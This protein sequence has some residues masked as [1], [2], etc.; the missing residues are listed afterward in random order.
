M[1]GHCGQLLQTFFRS[2]KSDVRVWRRGWNATAPVHDIGATSPRALGHRFSVRFRRQRQALAAP[3]NGP[4]YKA[5]AAV[6][7][8]SA[9]AL[10]EDS[11]G[12]SPRALGQCFL[13]GSEGNV[14]HWLHLE[15]GPFRPSLV[16]GLSAA[17]LIKNTLGTNCF[18]VR[19]RRQRQALAAP[20]NGPHYFAAVGGLSAAALVEDSLGTSP[21]ALGQC[22]LFGSEG[23]VRHWL[24]LETGPFRPSLV[25][26]LSAAALV[27]DSLGTNCF[28]VRFRR[29]RQALAAPRNGPHYKAFAAVGGLVE[30][31]LEASPRALGHC[32]FVRFRRQR[33]A[34]AAPRNG[35]HY[36]AFAAVGGLSAAALVEDSLGTSPGRLEGNL[37]KRLRRCL[38]T[39][40]V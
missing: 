13:F 20:R 26:G 19:F 17:A 27:E 38:P 2:S 33:Q 25:G 10:V 8:L 35:P 16:G 39:D 12:T 5:F 32:F 14:R 36:K 18:S 37:Q 9:A 34:L 28:F 11:L 29:Q 40:T 30:D 31:S 22:F 3:R 7:G 4:H 15:T 6:G 21:R 1:L 24:H 23:N